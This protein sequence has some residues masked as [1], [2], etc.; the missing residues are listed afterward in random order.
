[1]VV[2]V[3]AMRMVQVPGN[4]IIDMVAVWH[5]FMAAARA[6]GM[7]RFVTAAAMTRGAAIRIAAGD[8]DHMLVD[9]AVMRVVKMAVMQIVDVIAVTHGRVPATGPM[10]MSVIRVVW[11]RTSGHCESSFLSAESAGTAAR[12]SAA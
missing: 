10:P 5:R 12:L 4:M 6:V 7:I 8:A 3:I 2:A 1:M 11:F 9:M